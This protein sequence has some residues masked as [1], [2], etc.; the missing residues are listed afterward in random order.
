MMLTAV[1]VSAGVN[2]AAAA[3]AADSDYPSVV[4]AY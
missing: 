3:A 4:S 2:A 1:G